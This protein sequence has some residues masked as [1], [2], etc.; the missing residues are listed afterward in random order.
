MQNK[1]ILETC[2]TD[3]RLKHISEH[4]FPATPYLLTVPTT[5][6][7]DSHQANDWKRGSPFS[8]NEESLQYLTFNSH[9][10]D[11]TML[12]AVGDWDD[13]K[14]GI[15]E[16][17]PDTT[18]KSSS[19]L[20]TPFPGQP[21]RKK[22]SLQDYK[23]KTAGQ[24]GAKVLPRVSGRNKVQ[25]KVTAPAVLVEKK[26]E[27]HKEQLLQGQK[28]YVAIAVLLSFLFSSCRITILL[29]RCRPIGA[30][31]EDKGP[32]STGQDTVPSPAK[33]PRTS[34]EPPEIVTNVPPK[35]GTYIPKLPP[36]LSPTLPPSVEEELARRKA[37]VSTAATEKFVQ[38]KVAEA[39]SVTKFPAAPT[40]SRNNQNTA[41][42]ASKDVNA[43]SKKG[44]NPS[45][46]KPHPSSPV[47][48]T[49]GSVRDTPHAKQR[50][51]IDQKD[52]ALKINGVVGVK[53][54]INGLSSNVK[55]EFIASPVSKLVPT[56]SERKSLIVKLKIPKSAR[57]NLARIIGL[58]PGPKKP[59]AILAASTSAITQ[60]NQGSDQQEGK[61]I[62]KRKEQEPVKAG[63]KRRRS[64]E[65]EDLESSKR[66]KP[67]GV[68]NI[69]HKPYTPARTATKSPALSQ[70]SNR[71]KP[72]VP[73]PKRDIK[74]TAMHRIASADGD[75]KTPSGG[76]RNVTPTA[77][78][79]A[80]RATRDAKATSNVASSN[81]LTPERKGEI[82]LWKA[83]QVQYSKLGQKLKHEADEILQSK[84]P[85]DPAAKNRGIAIALE[86]VLCYMLAF[87][88]GDE[89]LRVMH[90]LGDVSAWRSLLGY[91]HFVKGVAQPI[92]H[93][94][95]LC[96][97]LEAVC[98]DTILLYELD[99]LDR[100]PFPSAGLDEARTATPNQE[101]MLPA[102]DSAAKATNGRREYL[103]F[104]SKFTEN[105]RLARQSWLT[106]ISR[107]PIDELQRSYPKTWAKRA[108]V[109]GAAKGKERLVLRRYGDGGFYLP[110]GSISSGIEA[111]RMGWSLLGEWCAKEGVN[112]EGKI[113]L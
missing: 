20:G 104:K 76:T 9:L 81:N 48:K 103:E 73:T 87:S 6:R 94:H 68:A 37:N 56:K 107:L 7:V 59:A 57:K 1:S 43:T 54:L 98:R 14:G 105:S 99:R 69:V 18:T 34:P 63:E 2:D 11:D 21:P 96:L 109:P 71:Q 16:K 65:K 49:S 45:V 29:T 15:P 38:K 10:F 13:G 17:S 92:P 42:L 31:S 85:I 79:S 46:P 82:A 41:K 113:P 53:P 112:W 74:G 26:D 84:E 24:A 33:K 5:C 78:G 19:G 52:K 30:I 28:R 91:L 77:P 51:S 27:P 36:L 66:Q 3:A 100:D 64:E 44:N 89:S 25:E 40:P 58:R 88:V 23:A 12:T 67:S 72:N 80:E 83:E 61:A 50:T 70:P 93:L 35:E 86:T 60:R 95:G 4:I 75:V 22:I 101:S 110:L 106:G 32:K 39:S 111:V 55:E 97:Q 90:K 108:K 102:I 47:A 8:A 62:Q